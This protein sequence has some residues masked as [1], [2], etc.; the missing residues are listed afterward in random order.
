VFI[1]ILVG[2]VINSTWLAE[3]PAQASET[4]TSKAAVATSTAF[5]KATFH[6]IYKN[7]PFPPFLQKICEAESANGHYDK[8]ASGNQRN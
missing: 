1:F 5:T 2:H 8:R 7:Y 6:E 4:A 3:E